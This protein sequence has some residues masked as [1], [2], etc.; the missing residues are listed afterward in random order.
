MVAK[1]RGL[2]QQVRAALEKDS[3]VVME[4]EPGTQRR[5]SLIKPLEGEIDEAGVMQ[6]RVQYGWVSTHSEGGTLLLVPIRKDVAAK[7]YKAV[8]PAMVRADFDVTSAEE[9]VLEVNDVIEVFD[10]RMTEGGILRVKFEVIRGRQKKKGWTSVTAKD[11]TPLLKVVEE[12][13]IEDE[14]KAAAAEFRPGIHTAAQYVVKAPALIRAQFHATSAERGVLNPGEIIDVLEGR[15]TDTGI[16]RVKFEQGWVNTKSK[17]GDVL[18]SAVGEEEEGVHGSSEMGSDDETEFTTG[19]D[20]WEEEAITPAAKYCVIAQSRVR[21]GF[22]TDSED[23]GIIDPGEIV[24]TLEGRVNRNGVMR[25]RF[26]GGWLSTVAG[27][28]TALLSEVVEEEQTEEHDELET[29]YTIDGSE[30]EEAETETDLSDLETIVTEFGKD[31][32]Q[33]YNVK[34]TALIREGVSQTTRGL[35]TVKP[36]EVIDVLEGRL[37][38]LGIMRV[39]THRG[40]LSVKSSDGTVLLEPIKGPEPELSDIDDETVES[41]SSYETESQ[42]SAAAGG[43]AKQYRVVVAAGAKVRSG[44]EATSDDMGVLKFGEVID[45]ISGRLNANGAMRVQFSRGWVSTKAGDG[46]ILLEAVKP[47]AK[48]YAK[49]YRVVLPAGAKIRAGFETASADLGIARLGEVLETLDGRLNANGVM[50]VQF[51]RGD[52]TGWVSTKAGDGTVLLEPVG[53]GDADDDE[54][55]YSYETETQTSRVS[56]AR[57][58]PRPAAKTQYKCVCPSKVRAG[59]DM[60]SKDLGILKPGEVVDALESRPLVAGK[61]SVLRIKFAWKGKHGWVSTAAG[62]GT[63]L[64]ELSGSGEDE[65]ESESEFETA[66]ATETETDVPAAAGEYRVLVP[67]KVRAGF[68]A[69]SPDAGICKPGEIIA[70][71][72][73]RPNAKGIMRIRFAR[74]WVSEKAMDGT[75]LLKPVGAGDADDDSD[76]SYETETQTSRASSSKRSNRSSKRAQSEE[77]DGSE[78]ETVTASE[79]QASSR[80]SGSRSAFEAG[81]DD[82]DDDDESWETATATSAESKRLARFMQETV[83]HAQ[84][85]TAT[86]FRVVVPAVVRAGFDASTEKCGIASPGEVIDA[87]ETR[88]NE[89]GVLRV[90]FASG[91]VS[92]TAGDGTRLLEVAAEEDEESSQWETDVTSSVWEEE[93]LPSDF[94]EDE[95][96]VMSTGR[97]V[98]VYNYGESEFETVGTEALLDTEFGEDV[99]T[100]YRVVHAA[101]IRAGFEAD[102]QR[103]GEATVGQV[104]DILEARLNAAGITRVRYRYGWLNTKASDGTVLLVPADDEATDS[105]WETETGTQYETVTETALTETQYETETESQYETEA[106]TELGTASQYYLVLAPARVRDQFEQDSS[107]M[108]VLEVGEIIETLEGRPNEA[109]IMRV[110]F[111]REKVPYGGWV[112]VSAG[113]GTQLLMPV[114]KD[115]A[116]IAEEE[117]D[118]ETEF[119]TEFETETGSVMSEDSV[120]TTGAEEWRLYTPENAEDFVDTCTR[121]TVLESVVVRKEFDMTSEFAGTLSPGEVVECLESK[122]NAQGI[123]R[124][125]CSIGWFSERA[126]DGSALVREGTQWYRVA[127]EAVVRTG[128]EISSARCQR[129][130]MPGEVIEAIEVYRIDSDATKAG[131]LRVRFK[132]G[133]TSVEAGNGVVLLVELN[134]AERELQIA[135]K[136]LLIEQQFGGGTT[137]PKEAPP[138]QK[139]KVR[140]E[141]EK[142]AREVV[143]QKI[144]EESEWLARVEEAK[145]TAATMTEVARWLEKARLPQFRRR[146]EAEGL[147]DIAVIKSLSPDR[148]EAVLAQVGKGMKRGHVLK[149]KIALETLQ[150]ELRHGTAVPPK[151]LGLDRDTGEEEIELPPEGQALL[152]DD[153]FVARSLDVH[154]PVPGEDLMAE[155]RAAEKER[156][157]AQER[158]AQIAKR[159][160]EEE[161]ARIVAEA[162]DKISQEA[163]ETNQRA[164]AGHARVQEE[165]EAQKKAEQE[166]AAALSAA[167]GAEEKWVSAGEER[168]RQTAAASGAESAAAVARETTDEALERRVAS[169]LWLTELKADLTTQETAAAAKQAEVA[170]KEEEVRLSIKEVSRVEAIAKEVLLAREAAEEELVTLKEREREASLNARLADEEAAAAEKRATRVAMLAAQLQESTLTQALLSAASEGDMNGVELL[171]EKGIDGV[172]P[173]ID[174]VDVNGEA[175]ITKAALNNHDEVVALLLAAGARWDLL[176]VGNWSVE[177]VASWFDREFQWFGKY[178]HQLDTAMIDGEALLEYGAP[179]GEGE[180]LLQTDLDISIGAH[181]KVLQT[182]IGELVAREEARA[183]RQLAA[184]QAEKLRLAGAIK[185]KEAERVREVEAEARARLVE[186]ETRRLEAEAAKTAKLSAKAKLGFGAGSPREN[187]PDA[188]GIARRARLD[189][190]LLEDGMEDPEPEELPADLQGELAANAAAAAADAIGIAVRAPSGDWHKMRVGRGVLVRELQARLVSR[191][192][193][194]DSA[195]SLT[196][197]G[198]DRRQSSVSR[199]TRRRC[200]TSCGRWRR[201]R[202]SVRAA[203]T[204]AMSST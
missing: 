78:W 165:A 159:K 201:A 202:R 138:V 100:Q 63:P 34:H 111:S 18:L 161:T 120:Y 152:P 14:I 55:D 4:F 198:V 144:K 146:F 9:G 40:W 70:A 154:Y 45:V 43:P 112:S 52:T 173:H 25:I 10:S 177:Q 94:D 11:G 184:A 91:W 131:L 115:G 114:T 59:F 171:L 172:K 147:D 99:A 30:T 35:G 76:Y 53:A 6:L 104:I 36:G 42:A 57:G 37:N 46:T 65:E 58:K 183:A 195:S 82:G 19:G 66:T 194:S 47:A 185:V 137:Q 124:I 125:K 110:R 170:L 102:S 150:G 168:A 92:E 32:A 95:E 163:A 44:F 1:R 97:Q 191:T 158:S 27:D 179:G 162:K 28:G 73:S 142:Q 38:E 204:R 145:S 187:E 126:S 200:C 189:K 197:N 21:A 85:R 128:R 49:R 23:M 74:G 61:P 153:A 139:W 64:L 127:S 75:R 134:E 13:D 130:L 160:E 167:E 182:R 62:D 180:R 15:E 149:L 22:A 2:R 141:A 193:A 72:E 84:T 132:R 51:R 12:A 151:Q 77:D 156:I 155:L 33:Q 109:G 136:K 17:D 103:V 157:A 71:L 98:K 16:L 178:R 31:L 20:S 101:Q 90:R 87:I 118:D 164:D 148:I 122:A 188:S 169:Q 123:T 119:E 174:V 175:A 89:S 80:K 54:S 93:S 41:D 105:E 24:E 181:R 176:P 166:S 8:A 50:R 116:A 140:M 3:K 117:E 121:Y 203:W 107:L 190:Q 199:S 83:E 67:A 96:T 196:C 106:E 81:T 88:K 7:K 143:L 133:W 48:P 192:S 26:G 69:T 129:N 60:K 135:A 29:V 68:D 86:R 108:G 79:S 39:R 56:S 5:P 113:D 186:I